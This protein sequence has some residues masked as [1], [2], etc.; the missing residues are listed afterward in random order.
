MWALSGN[1]SNSHNNMV[2]CQNAAHNM[3]IRFYHMKPNWTSSRIVHNHHKR[4][5]KVTFVHNK[6]T[7]C[8]GGLSTRS[9][10]D[11]QSWPLEVKPKL[12]TCVERKNK[13][14]LIQLQTLSGLRFCPKWL[15]FAYIVHWVW[16]EPY[17]DQS[18]V[19]QYVGN[20][21]TFRMQTQSVIW[22]TLAELLTLD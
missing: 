15:P 3:P 4:P 14:I 6:D 21:V 2:G 13:H 10:S 1:I 20:R 16:P 5:R 8:M 22:A 9:S 17:G 19:V 11:R 12:K 7:R 18:K